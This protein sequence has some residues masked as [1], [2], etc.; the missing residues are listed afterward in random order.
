MATGMA[1]LAETAPVGRKVR[2]KSALVKVGFALTSLVSLLV[3]AHAVITLG[4]FYYYRS[5]DL[6]VPGVGVGGI[7]LGGK[8]E[9]Q[10]AAELD[11]VWN[12]HR[13]IIVVDSR[14]VT[15]TWTVAPSEFGLAVDAPASASIAFGVGRD[16]GFWSDL[17]D[18]LYSLDRGRSFDPMVT[19]DLER[20]REAFSRWAERV[21]EP[22]EEASIR[23]EGGEVIHTA[24]RAGFR[25]DVEGSLDLLSS[26]PEAVMLEYGF[27]PL[28]MAPQAPSIQ[29]YNE[30]A[31]EVDALLNA[32]PSLRAYDPV[33]DE[34]FQWQPER[35]ELASWLVLRTGL[36]EAGLEVADAWL[37]S[38]VEQVD[39]NLGQE[40]TFDHTAAREALRTALEG[41]TGEVVRINY[42]PREHV[43]RSRDTLV[44]IGFE[45]GLPYWQILNANPEIAQRGLVRGET[46]KIPPRDVMLELPIIPEKRIV[47][48]LG[49]QRMW[50]YQQG[51]LHWEFIIS[52]G[53][54]SSP[55]LPGVF[56]VQS[57][58]LNAY[59]SIWDLYMPHFM[60]IYK[61]TPDLINGIHG[62][63]LLSNGVRLWSD[64]LGQPASFGCIILD[65][66][67]AEQLYDWAEEGV[68]VE[69][70]R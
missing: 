27:I 1:D 12:L 11:R 31:A 67:A 24:G 38:F 49:E 52:S 23:I 40:R 51:G 8:T 35:E 7:A 5:L 53:I 45:T 60:G 39:Q 25:L 28:L 14:D 62:L 61:A 17:N 59:A 56:Q 9:G 69:I 3:L 30:L 64:V 13:T 58:E 18:T 36:E 41:G 44:S 43:V 15:R 6:I 48:S 4:A 57:H 37:D 50:V 2:G 26:D 46:I 29:D 63:P 66:E 20:A 42:R 34:G 54:P 22:T 10:A 19:F 70:R 47:I 32:P 68:V 55:T 16:Q 65:L 21:Y 33:T